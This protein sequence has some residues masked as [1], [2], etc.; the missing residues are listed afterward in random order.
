MVLKVVPI[1]WE[2][3]I[4]RKRAERLGMVQ[5]PDERTAITKAA[6]QFNV[7]LESQNRIL[8]QRVIGKL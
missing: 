8:V 4:I 6:E 1:W 7:R 2:V 5:A 3:F